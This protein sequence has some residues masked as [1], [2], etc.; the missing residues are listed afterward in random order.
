MEDLTKK[1]LGAGIRPSCRRAAWVVL[2]I[3]VP[4]LSARNSTPP[5]EKGPYKPQFK[6][7]H[8][9]FSASWGIRWQ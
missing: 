7:L 9:C 6:E 2:Q 8:T 4:L 5:L 3:R 1:G